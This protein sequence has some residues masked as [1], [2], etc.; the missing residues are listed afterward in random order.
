[1]TAKGIVELHRQRILASYPAGGRGRREYWYILKSPNGR[2][3]T[4]SKTIHSR[5]N[6]E[7][8]IQKYFGEPE[9]K[10]KDMTGD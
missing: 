1:M 5:V 3:L 6:T 10:F 4:T 2:T 8:V 9:W 7:R